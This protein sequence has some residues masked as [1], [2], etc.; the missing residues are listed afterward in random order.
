MF[1]YL[2]EIEEFKKYCIKKTTG[3]LNNF[4]ITALISKKLT[5]SKIKYIPEKYPKII[6][7][8]NEMSLKKILSDFLKL[9]SE[10]NAKLNKAAE[11]TEIAFERKISCCKML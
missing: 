9:Y 1:T 4:A 6:T 2:K 7:K 10:L 5:S 8:I 3:R 11:D